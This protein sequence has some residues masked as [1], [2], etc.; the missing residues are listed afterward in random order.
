MQAEQKAKSEYWVQKYYEY[1][2]RVYSNILNTLFGGPEDLERIKN[3]LGNASLAVEWSGLAEASKGIQ[4]GPV[5]KLSTG[6]GAANTIIA[7][8]NLSNKPQELK[9]WGDVGTGV[10]G[11]GGSALEALG[12]IESVNLPVSGGLL[13][14]SSLRYVQDNLNTNSQNLKKVY[15]IPSYNPSEYNNYIYQKQFRER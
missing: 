10:I 9:Y 8:D 2:H 6:L 12:L 11:L 4:G 7:F 13:I 5:S 1:G 3:D 15:R 14:Y